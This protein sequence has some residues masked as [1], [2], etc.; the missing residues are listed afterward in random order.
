MPLVLSVTPP[1]SSRARLEKTSLSELTTVE[2]DPEGSRS[3]VPAVGD[4]VKIPRWPDS[5][6]STDTG[7]VV[8]ALSSAAGGSVGRSGVFMAACTALVTAAVIVVIKASMS[9]LEQGLVAVA[10]GT[11]VPV[12]AEGSERALLGRPREMLPDERLREDIAF[13]KV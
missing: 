11:T 9:T 13:Q 7:A 3:V 6:S 12:E 8:L 4:D 10:G 5:A 1:P 2:E